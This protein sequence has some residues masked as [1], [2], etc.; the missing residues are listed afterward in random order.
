MGHPNED[1][2]IGTQLRVDTWPLDL[3]GDVAPVVQLRLVNLRQGG[4]CEGLVVELGVQFLGRRAELLLDAPRALLDGAGR[5]L[6]LK[7]LFLHA[8]QLRFKLPGVGRLELQADLD[9][10][11]EEALKKLRK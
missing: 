10:D 9:I 2:H 4:C 8:H 7:R 6:G 5:E 11:L 1:P 3:D